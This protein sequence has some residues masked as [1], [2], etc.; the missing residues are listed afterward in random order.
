LKLLKG[1]RIKWVV[2]NANPSERTKCQMKGNSERFS[3][4]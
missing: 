1:K 4:I 3:V 2:S